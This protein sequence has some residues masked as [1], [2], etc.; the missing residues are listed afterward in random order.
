MPID[1]DLF[2]SHMR[3]RG[4]V[5][6]FL[7]GHLWVEKFLGDLLEAV[8]ADPAAIQLDRMSFSQKVGLA[9][10]L[11][12]VASAEAAP[13]RV[14]NK[15]RNR[16]AH[17]LA[18]DPTTKDLAVLE[19]SLSGLQR[20][21]FDTQLVRHPEAGEIRRLEFVVHSILLTIES[22]RQNHVYESENSAAIGSYRLIRA[23]E[24]RSGGGTPNEE[25]MRRYGVPEPPW[26]HDLWTQ[27]REI[28]YDDLGR[29]IESGGGVP[30]SPADPLRSNV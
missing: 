26:P 21:L 8:L 3:G 1:L 25:L 18:G 15:T 29:R 19:D 28:E 12:A 11:G 20:K 30:N 4:L 9:Q 7:R 13:L 6:V 16:L 27:G 17:D 24:E 23:L 2:M 22:R 14:M 10:A 5:E